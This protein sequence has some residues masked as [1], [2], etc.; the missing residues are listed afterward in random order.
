M[1]A[2]CQVSMWRWAQGRVWEWRWT[3]WVGLG[4][5]AQWSNMAIAGARPEGRVHGEGMQRMQSAGGRL[6]L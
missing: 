5:I 4:P 3:G 1:D 2:P 6:C